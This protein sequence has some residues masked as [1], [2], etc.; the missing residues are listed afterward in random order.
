MG[1]LPQVPYMSPRQHTSL[2]FIAF[3]LIAMV[4]SPLQA[5]QTTRFPSAAAEYRTLRSQEHAER[6]YGEGEFAR[7]LII[8]EKELSLIGDKYAQYMVGYMHLT[9]KGVEVN[10]AA[11]LA[12]YRLAA[13]RRDI[14]IMQARDALFHSLPHEEVVE[15]NAIYL[16]L[17][18][19]LGDNRLILN[20]VQK[21]LKILRSRTGSRIEGVARGPIQVMIARSGDFQSDEYYD[22]IQKRIDMRL[23]YLDTNV[24]IIDLDLDGE[25]AVK[26]SLESEIKEEM[27]GLDIR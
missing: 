20:L 19:E 10:R 18:R 4:C 3:L 12:W 5:G 17:W 6:L 7:A 21:D 13:E 26:Q 9:G 23:Q 22:R 2:V 11:A 1:R 16:S 25:L 27:A 8:Y 15:S 24:E 14:P